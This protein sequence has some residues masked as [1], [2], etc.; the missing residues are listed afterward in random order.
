MAKTAARKQKPA[1]KKKPAARAKT[2]PRGA[3]PAVK[4]KPPARSAAAVKPVKVVKSA[5]QKWVY[6]FGDGK[7]EGKADMKNFRKVRK[8]ATMFLNSG[9][10]RGIP[11]KSLPPANDRDNRKREA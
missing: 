3:A 8:I 4:R 1:P 10:I 9:C 7:A 2:P 11:G 6:T 5:R